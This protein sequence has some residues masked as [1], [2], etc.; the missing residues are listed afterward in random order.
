MKHPI[1]ISALLAFAFVVL[2]ASCNQDNS[3]ESSPKESSKD[4]PRMAGFKGKI[5]KKLKT[6]KKIGP[7]E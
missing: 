6:Q 2:M 7:R 4:D 5:A 1:K 3:K